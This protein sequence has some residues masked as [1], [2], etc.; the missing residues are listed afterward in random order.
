LIDPGAAAERFVPKGTM[1]RVEEFGNG[2]INETFLVTPA[3]EHEAP[4]ILQKINTRVFRSP[5]LVM[6][7]L[8]VCG[9]HILRRLE[10]APPAEG[11]RWEVP[12]VIAASDGRDYWIDS[13]GSFWRAITFIAGATAPETIQ[14]G[15]HAVQVGH[16]L[17]MFHA[18]LSD[19][20]A[21][22]L[23]D[24]LPGFHVTPLYL[25]HHYDVRSR[26][27][28]KDTAEV[29]YCMRFV[30]ERKGLAHLL[31]NAKSRNV[32]QVRPI[33]GDPK[34]DN[35]MIDSATGLAVGM[36]D[37]DTVKP[38][39]VH[40]DIGDCLRSS[41]NPL[42]EETEAWDKVGFDPDIGR[43]ILQ[44]YLTAAG[45]S[46]TVRD[47]SFLHA[48]ARLIAFE[49]GLRFFTDYLEGDM[50]FKV[51]KPEHNLVRALVQFRLCES[52]EAQEAVIEA[53]IRD[54]Q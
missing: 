12:R 29:K 6:G 23:A 38:G 53:V 36:V 51:T 14:D 1:V 21:D 16:G 27:R 17:G 31:E 39:L 19:L 52:I 7:N 15:G 2:N 3:A 5:E 35:I 40:Y 54:V 24:T 45:G 41:C 50:Y 47:F 30:D 37:L 8:R 28:M 10:D 34:V 9:D 42:G 49:L 43:L 18:L 13:D 22:R 32:L 33:H 26:L 4:F 44:G 20:P 25:D 46:L 11:R 48:S